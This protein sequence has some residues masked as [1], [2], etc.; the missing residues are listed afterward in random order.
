MHSGQRHGMCIKSFNTYLKGHILSSKPS[1]KPGSSNKGD[2]TTTQDIAGP[3][4][5]AE[6]SR[7]TWHGPRERRNGY[8]TISTAA[9]YR[10]ERRGLSGFDKARDWPEAESEIESLPGADGMPE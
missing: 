1:S 6:V 5:E 4:N 10:T 9:Y 7:Q 8:Q 3:V 2:L